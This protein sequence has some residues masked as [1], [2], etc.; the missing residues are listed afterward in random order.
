M[1]ADPTADFVFVQPRLLLGLLETFFN[2][3][4]TSR[5]PHQ[6][7]EACP[8]RSVR[9]KVSQFVRMAD[10]SAHQEAVCVMIV[11][12]TRPPE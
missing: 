1:P 3:P 8:L 5:D 7:L 4:T 9:E 10:R 12:G 2:R 11:R 6:C